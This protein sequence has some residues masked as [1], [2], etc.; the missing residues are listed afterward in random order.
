MKILG[1][2][3]W[4]LEGFSGAFGSF[5]PS[6]GG[7]ASRGG[8]SSMGGFS[9]TGLALGLVL[10]GLGFGFSFN[11]GASVNSKRAIGALSPFL[12]EMRMIRV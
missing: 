7:F 9:S 2:F 12:E 10:V 6:R 5:S 11:K 3:S 1:G 8:F 4:S